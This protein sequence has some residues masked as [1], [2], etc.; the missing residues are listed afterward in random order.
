MAKSKGLSGWHSM[1]KDQL[2]AALVRAAKKRAKLRA[3]AAPAKPK[4]KKLSR[5]ATVKARIAVK[6]HVSH[7]KPAARHTNGAKVNGATKHAVAKANGSVER[8]AKEPPRL[9]AKQARVAERIHKAMAE[10]ERLKDLS[11]SFTVSKS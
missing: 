4:A 3:V 5:H 2:V 9:S 10:R 7:G 6:S 8:V 11:G 1:R